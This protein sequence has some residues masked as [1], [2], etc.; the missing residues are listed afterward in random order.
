MKK[1]RLIKPQPESEIDLSL[2]GR[3]KPKR[4]PPETDPERQERIHHPSTV[5]RLGG[6]VR[7]QVR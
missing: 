7:L 2:V 5:T 1:P 6:L 4:E 3:A